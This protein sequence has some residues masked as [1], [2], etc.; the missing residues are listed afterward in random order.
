MAYVLESSRAGY[1][2]DREV[3][4]QAVEA[5][6]D[7]PAFDGEHTT[8][9]RHAATS[10]RAKSFDLHDCLVSAIADERHTRVLSFDQDLRRLGNSER[11]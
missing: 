9:L 3:V 2:W 5:V 8:A 10:Y 11:P 1:D 7:E 6:T 4:A